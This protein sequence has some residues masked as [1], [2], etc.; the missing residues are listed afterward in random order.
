MATKLWFPLTTAAA[1]SVTPDAGWETT[2]GFV[3]RV[4]V[5]TKGSSTLTDESAYTSTTGQDALHRQYISFPMDAGIDFLIASTGITCQLMAKESATNDNATNRLGIRIVSRDGST[6]RATILPIGANGVTTEFNTS[7]R[8]KIFANTGTAVDYT[9][10]D[11]DRLVVEIGHNDAGGASISTTIN[12]GETGTDLTQGNETQTTGN[13]WVNFTNTITFQAESQNQTVLPGVGALA[14]AGFAPILAG[15]IIAG[16]SALTVNGFI[17]IIGS[18]INAGTGQPVIT[19]FS[20]TIISTQN[21]T[22]LS[23]TGAVVA[24]GFSP[25]ISV[26]NN[27]RALPGTGQGSVNGLAPVINQGINTGIG[28]LTIN[29]FAPQT[30][31]GVNVFPGL[32]LAVITG[33]APS[34]VLSNNQI[35]QSGLGQLTLNGFSPILNNKLA[36]GLGQLTINAF[37]PTITVGSGTVVLPGLGQLSL[38]GFQPVIKTSIISGMGQLTITGLAPIIQKIVL[39]GLGQLTVSGLSP[40]INVSNNKVVAAGIGQLSIQG[41]SPSILIPRIIN[42]GAGLLIISGFSP[43]IDNVGGVATTKKLVMIGHFRKSVNL[44]SYFKNVALKSGINDVDVDS[45]INKQIKKTSRFI[46]TIK[47]V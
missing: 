15:A 43:I 9:T 27:I 37:A 3:S 42:P 12:W 25:T 26:S 24:T 34:I 36:I 10:V 33:A 45:E 31:I 38:S 5:S 19:G 40:I 16:L 23:G 13:G 11:G 1:V 47:N 2:A 44:E 8:S 14:S 32:G 46:K 17:P 20:P 39:S 30:K 35:V 22:A 6:V 41:F 4:L 28:Q 21:Q 29:G 18:G 7:N